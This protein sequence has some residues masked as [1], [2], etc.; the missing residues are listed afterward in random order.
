MNRRQCRLLYCKE[1]PCTRRLKVKKSLNEVFALGHRNTQT[2][3]SCPANSCFRIWTSLPYFYVFTTTCIYQAILLMLLLILL[4]PFHYPITMIFCILL[5]ALLRLHLLFHLKRL[6]N[7]Q[8]PLYR[9][10]LINCIHP[11]LDALKFVEIYTSPL[12]PVHPGEAREV[13]DRAFRACEPRSGRT[14][15]TGT[16]I[17]LS[18]WRS[19]GTGCSEIGG[20]LLGEA[21]LED[22]VEAFGLLI[23]VSEAWT[24]RDTEDRLN[25]QPQFGTAW[26]HILS[27][28]ESAGSWNTSWNT[29]PSQAHT[30]RS[31]WL[32]PAYDQHVFQPPSLLFAHLFRY[33]K[34]C[35]PASAQFHSA[36][37]SAIPQLPSICFRQQKSKHLPLLAP[38]KWD[39]RFQNKLTDHCQKDT[40]SCTPYR[41]SD[42][43]TTSSLHS[44]ISSLVHDPPS[45][46]PLLEYGHW[47]RAVVSEVFHGSARL[48]ANANSV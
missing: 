26:C 32:G 23:L 40:K 44:Q 37:R 15:L 42:K 20:S 47:L 9:R 4:L 27:A 31:D 48:T 6:R 39:L 14:G 21:V 13:C 1:N 28:I 19:F 12:G 25:H 22:L 16:R 34:E 24:H 11:L 29:V 8:A 36:S 18:C 33:W 17:A 41:T 46:R 7:I 5:L 3:V 10:P 38:K 30:E 45:D 2:P 35:T 43:D